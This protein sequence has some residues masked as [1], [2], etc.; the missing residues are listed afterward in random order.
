MNIVVNR[1]CNL[2]ITL[3]QILDFCANKRLGESAML[4]ADPIYKDIDKLSYNIRKSSYINEI[5]LF[6]NSFSYDNMNYYNM[7]LSISKYLS[8]NTL[9]EDKE[10][11][12]IIDHIKRCDLTDFLPLLLFDLQLNIE[13]DDTTEDDIFSM[14]EKD[15]KEQIKNFLK[16]SPVSSELKWSLFYLID[17]FDLIK[18]NYCN[19]LI[20]CYEEFNVQLVRISKKLDKWCDYIENKISKDGMEFLENL[21]STKYLNNLNNIYIHGNLLINY[22]IILESHE[23]GELGL[24]LGINID[25]HLMKLRGISSQEWF[26]NSAKTLSDQSKINILKLLSIRPMYGGEL[27]EALNLTTATISH[28]ISALR[29]IEFI[30]E[31]VSSNRIF[32]ELN[33]ESIEKW[34]EMFKEELKLD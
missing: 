30:K 26:F 34:I 18:S 17:D 20:K 16:L 2:F 33:K 7:P 12:E 10:F 13:E 28:H 9:I 23:Y 25:K 3:I 21:V 8:N 24:G 15:M 1:K 19:L 22:G 32:C 27:A 11:Y 14:N 5:N 6:F 31:E 4:L 29:E